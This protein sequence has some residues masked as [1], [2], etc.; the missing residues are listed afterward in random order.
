MGYG[1]KSSQ[2]VFLRHLG[3][4]LQLAF[5]MMVG[6]HKNTSHGATVGFLMAFCHFVTPHMLILQ[7]R[8]HRMRPPKSTYP[9][10]GKGP[11]ELVVT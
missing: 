1:R 11:L 10:K 2:I 6:S 4:G 8:H 7:R 3:M 5:G 9:Q